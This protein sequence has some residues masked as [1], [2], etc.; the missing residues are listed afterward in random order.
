MLGK[1]NMQKKVNRLVLDQ[2]K[3]NFNYFTGQYLNSKGKTY[4]LLYDFA[5]MEVNNGE[6]LI[7]SRNKVK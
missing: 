5:W 4:C 3:F 7:L 1:N 2:K 6:I